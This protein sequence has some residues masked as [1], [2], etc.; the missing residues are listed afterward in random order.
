MIFSLL[1]YI[2]IINL[3]HVFLT[4][5]EKM[6]TKKTNEAAVVDFKSI[7]KTIIDRVYY[8]KTKTYERLKEYLK[9]L[10]G[11]KEFQNS[12]WTIP[13]LTKE[14]DDE[15]GIR[16]AI[17]ITSVVAEGF[18][19]SWIYDSDRN[20]AL[21]AAQDFFKE[22]VEGPRRLK[23]GEDR[24]F[25]LAQ[26]LL[27]SA[28]NYIVEKTSV[29]PKINNSKQ[30]NKNL[31]NQLQEPIPEKNCIAIS[32]AFINYINTIEKGQLTLAKEIGKIIP[33]G[34]ELKPADFKK[35]VYPNV[36]VIIP[37][38]KT[39]IPD[40][41]IPLDPKIPIPYPKT[42]LDPKIPIPRPEIKIHGPYVIKDLEIKLAEVE[43]IRKSLPKNATKAEKKAAANAEQQIKNL[44]KA[45]KRAEPKAVKKASVQKT[46]K[47]KSK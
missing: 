38:P 10:Q 7:K 15:A 13:E 42:P 30:I 12:L 46:P 21:H 3:Y 9:K 19:H 6:A 11:D 18:N 31:L 34:I 26:A 8:E 27:Q 47:K 40:P 1:L 43:R 37:Y 16:R 17:G 14:G 4:Q 39:P 29:S 36:D 41:K 23:P 44:L 33:E 32:K 5:G 45:A 35:P 25:E 28:R 22:Y 24:M 20:E 2:H